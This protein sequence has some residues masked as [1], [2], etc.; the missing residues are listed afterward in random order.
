MPVEVKEYKTKDDI[1]G[2]MHRLQEDMHKLFADHPTMDFSTDQ[3]KDIREM[4][5]ELAELGPK[6]E[7]LV[8]LETIAEQAK[9]WG[10]I[11]RPAIYGGAPGGKLGST[12]DWQKSLGELIVGSDAVGKFSPVAR[13]GPEVDLPIGWLLAGN[14]GMAPDDVKATAGFQEAKALL[15][16]TGYPLQNVRLP[17]VPV[18]LP[19][20]TPWLQEMIPSAGTNQQAIPYLEETLA[21]NGAA[22]V[23]EGAA[24]PESALEFEERTSLVRKIA[25]VLPLTDEIM[26]DVPALQGYIDNRLTLF[27][28]LEWE[29]QLLLGSGIAP[30]LLGLM[31]TPGIQTQAKG[32]D[33]TPDAIYRG[34]QKIRT[35]TY[36]EPTGVV[37]HPDD[38]T[39]IRLLKTTDGVYIWGHPSEVGLDRLWGL[40]VRQTPLI[41]LGTALVGAFNVGSQQFIRQ[42]IAFAISTEH[43]SF[44]VENKIML[45]VEMRLAHVVFRPAAYCTVTGI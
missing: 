6:L 23:A 11:K 3:V 12:P 28:K 27:L 14:P 4:N 45:R 35:L 26:S 9:G 1:E 39:D 41:T 20:R 36:F 33:P 25:T 8:E 29:R 5:K 44:F 22:A 38:W 31:L 10:N 34:M 13:K 42:G 19:F 2:R 43:A 16:T 15:D 30:N 37:M 32:A 7:A 18:T 21:T 40:T 24:K 17:G